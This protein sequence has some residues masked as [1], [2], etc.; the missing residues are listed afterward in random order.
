M[1]FSMSAPSQQSSTLLDSWVGRWLKDA[2]ER[3]LGL[4]HGHASGVLLVRF[5]GESTDREVRLLA[6]SDG[7]GDPDPAARYRNPS[8][9]E[10]ERLRQLS[11]ARRLGGDI[12]PQLLSLSGVVEASS[13]ERETLHRFCLSACAALDDA[14]GSQLAR[15]PAA[16]KVRA[17]TLVEVVELSFSGRRPKQGPP[18]SRYE[19]RVHSDL[20]FLASS[21]LA[22][23]LARGLA[24]RL[25]GLLAG[26][27]VRLALG[28]GAG[29]PARLELVAVRA[30]LSE[31][32]LRLEAPHLAAGCGA[33]RLLPV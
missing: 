5:P 29:A 6:D 17:D 19:L 8:E 23:L 33:R 25:E 21:Q 16:L 2:D 13:R 14:V 12:E 1:L 18:S 26:P 10:L 24:E 11:A 27:L 31:Q 30:E 4:V 20:R 7:E 15:L 28:T 9:A 32:G 22:E 3:S